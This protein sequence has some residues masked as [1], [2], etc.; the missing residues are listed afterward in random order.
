[1]NCVVTVDIRAVGYRVPLYQDSYAGTPEGSYDCGRCAG[2]WVG[3][4]AGDTGDERVCVLAWLEC[5]ITHRPQKGVE[6]M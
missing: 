5:S 4:R 6:L 2:G 3:G 1:M